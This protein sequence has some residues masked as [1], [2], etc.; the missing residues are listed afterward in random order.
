MGR[1]L[2]RARRQQLKQRRSA[3]DEIRL[4]ELNREGRDRAASLGQPSLTP[5]DI[6]EEYALVRRRLIGLNEVSPRSSREEVLVKVNRL[7]DVTEVVHH[8]DRSTMFLL[9]TGDGYY[10]F[11][12]RVKGVYYK[13]SVLYDSRTKAMSR[14]DTNRIIWDSFHSE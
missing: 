9:R 8:V 10:Y 11:V 6:T 7:R 5:V 13:K 2:T 3:I 14:Y 1:R 4:R 12:F